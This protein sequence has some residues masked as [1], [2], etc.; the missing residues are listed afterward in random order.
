MTSAR[1]RHR[2]LTPRRA[3]ALLG[4]L[5]ALGAPAVLGAGPALA[6]D[7]GDDGGGRGGGGDRRE[8]RVTGTC[9]RGASI[10]LRLRSRDGELRADVELDHARRGSSWRLVLVQDRRVVWRGRARIGPGSDSAEI[11]RRLRDLPGADSVSARAWGPGGATCFVAA[12]L[13]G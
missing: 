7:G 13:A 4:V 1:H 2:L 12:T 9:D 3:L 11:E 5:G 6:R 8:V 10:R